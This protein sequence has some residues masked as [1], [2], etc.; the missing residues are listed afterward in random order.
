M[1]VGEHHRG[2][3]LESFGES[4]SFNDDRSCVETWIHWYM[5]LSPRARRYLKS[6][7]WHVKRRGEGVTDTECD[8]KTDPERQNGKGCRETGC[9]AQTRV[10]LPSRSCL[11]V[12]RAG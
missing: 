8:S 7:L 11:G 5:S 9:T 2:I 4:K 6:L 1:I 3:V 10:C 12:P